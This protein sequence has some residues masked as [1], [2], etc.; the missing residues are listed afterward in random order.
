[1]ND[2]DDRQAINPD[3]TRRRF[4]QGSALA[5]VAAF[6]AACT[7]SSGTAA[8]SVAGSGNANIPT[9]PPA[10]SATPAASPTP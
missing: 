1:M 9:P 5:G 3:L 6:L 10:P 4:L 2:R 7:G 8:P